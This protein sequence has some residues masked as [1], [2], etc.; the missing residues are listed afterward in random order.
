MKK[1]YYS[2]PPQKTKKVK[3]Q[4]EIVSKTKKCDKVTDLDIATKLQQLHRSA[5]DRGLTFNLT[6][7]TVKRLLM[8]KKCYYTGTEFKSTG[9]YSRSI[10]RIDTNLGYNEGNVVAC[11]VDI[12]G[13]K[14]NLSIQEISLLHK[15]ISNHQ[16]YK[17]SK[18]V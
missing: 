11:T 8:V 15:I 13:K 16:S 9:P 4:I 14:S 7:K 3:V 2:K 12:N 6:L 10:D 5:Q 17:I 18:H 1:P